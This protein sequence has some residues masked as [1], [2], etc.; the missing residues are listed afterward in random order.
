MKAVINRLQSLCVGQQQLC[1]KSV[2]QVD[3]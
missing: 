3:T 2:L 1:C